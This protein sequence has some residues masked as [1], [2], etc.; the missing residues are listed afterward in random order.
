MVPLGIAVGLVAGWLAGFVMKQ[1]GD[2]RI[3]P[4][5]PQD[6]NY[7]RHGRTHDEYQRA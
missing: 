3:R 1:G 7:L 5:S 6:F 4:Q 2:G